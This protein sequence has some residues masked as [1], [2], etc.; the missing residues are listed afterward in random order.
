MRSA[1]E[2]LQESCGR[3][4]LKS[5]QFATASTEHFM[6]TYSNYVNA[7][8]SK[9]ISDLENELLDAKREIKL[10]KSIIEKL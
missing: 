7:E 1:K 6:T 4:F 2:Y 10:L 5:G 8:K 9:V 3:V